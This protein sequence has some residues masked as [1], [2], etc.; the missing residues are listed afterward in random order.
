MVSGSSSVTCFFGDLPALEGFEGKDV[1]VQEDASCFRSGGRFTFLPLGLPGL[2]PRPS[3]GAAGEVDG[4]CV[5][6]C[7]HGAVL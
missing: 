6:L 1:T 2:R 5:E 4:R 3:P 7:H